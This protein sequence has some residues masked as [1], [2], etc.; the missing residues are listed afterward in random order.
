MAAKKQKSKVLGRDWTTDPSKIMFYLMEH[1]PKFPCEEK[2]V[3]NSC[4]LKTSYAHGDAFRPY[5]LLCA[6]LGGSSNSVNN[7]QPMVSHK[8]A[9]FVPLTNNWSQVGSSSKHSETFS[10]KQEVLTSVRFGQAPNASEEMIERFVF[11]R[12]K[13]HWVVHPGALVI[14]WTPTN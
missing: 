2:Q 3:G 1:L 10:R 6:P 14:C 7:S 12:S 11:L 9:S 8:M 13:P 4:H 5:Q